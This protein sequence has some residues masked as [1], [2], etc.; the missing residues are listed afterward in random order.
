MLFGLLILI[1]TISYAQPTGKIINNKPGGG[2][3]ISDT[4]NVYSKLNLYQTTAGQTITLGNK[5][6]GANYDL[7]VANIGSQNVTMSPGGTLPYGYEIKYRW[8]GLAWIPSATYSSGSGTVTTV[9][10]SSANGF[11]G[12]VSN[13]TTTPAITLSTTISGILK[14]NGTAISAASSGTDYVIP[15]ALNSYLLKSG[16]TMAGPINM[17]GNTISNIDLIDGTSGNGSLNFTLGTLN[18]AGGNASIDFNSNRLLDQFGQR[19]ID[20]SVAGSPRIYNSTDNFYASLIFS[21]TANRSVTFPDA[22]GTVVYNDNTTALTNKTYN[23]VTLSGSSTPSLAVSG[24]ASISGSNT[25]DQTNISGNAA[26]ATNVAWSGVTSTP[27]TRSGYGITDALGGNGTANYIPYY[28]GTTTL[29]NDSLFTLTGANPARYLSLGFKT[30]STSVGNLLHIYNAQNTAAIADNS[31]LMLE[32]VNRNSI[33][34]FRTSSTA[35]ASILH[36]SNNGATNYAQMLIAASVGKHSFQLLTDAVQKLYV[37][38]AGSVVIGS[39]TSPSAATLRLA[40][41]ITGNTNSIGLYSNGTV[42]SDVTSAFYNFRSDANTQATSFTLPEYNHFFANQPSLG[43]GSAI[44]TQRGFYVNS[45]VTSATNNRAFEGALAS[46]TNRFNLYM[47]GTAN[48]FLN[49]NLGIGTTPSAALH[50]AQAI[51]SSAWTTSGIGLRIAATTY[52]DN[53]SSG[54]VASNYIHTFGSPTVAASSTTTYTDLVN[55]F[56]DIPVVST[57]VT[58]TNLYAAKFGGNLRFT[59]GAGQTNFTFGNGLTINCGSAQVYAVQMNG[60][61]K[62]GIS[63]TGNHTFSGTAQSSGTTAFTTFTAPT[64]TGGS[65][66]GLLFTGAPNT[67]QT[68]GTEIHDVDLNINRTVTWSTTVPTT[69]RF[70]RVR[71]PTMSC[72]SVSTSTTAST[73]VIDGPP[74]AAGSA[75]ITNAYSINVASGNSIFAGDVIS[76]KFRLSALNTAPSSAGDTGTLG[77]IRIDANNIYICTATNTW[78]RVA[79]ATF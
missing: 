59:S 38:T 29:A 55:V 37:D 2:T 76:S 13:A 46:G 10:V 41:N 3:I 60:A 73:F 50:I 40:K 57:N 67:G 77:E 78:K 68:S 32:S 25:G 49:G 36:Q 61:N 19:V 30:P 45:N 5:T 27:T 48:N 15:S 11:A 28:S 9:S 14:G 69:Q 16:G 63:T 31:A 12:S 39:S 75:A 7:F 24:T 43:A 42:Q 26:T 64:H 74:L 35:S 23:G 22:N 54:T 58:A 4:V 79:I 44:T 8:T 65:A 72:A 21:P 53:S 47:S 1:S 17:G 62:Y 18:G 51:T 6:S 20:W 33:L 34:Y 66:G 71:Q 70:I 56:F 52:T